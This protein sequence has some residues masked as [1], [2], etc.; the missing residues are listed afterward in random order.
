MNENQKPAKDVLRW[1]LSVIRLISGRNNPH[2][3]RL[4]WK[5]LASKTALETST[6]QA[7]L[8][9]SGMCAKH[10]HRTIKHKHRLCSEKKDS[11][12]WNMQNDLVSALV[13]GYPQPLPHQ[14]SSLNRSYAS[15]LFSLTSRTP[16]EILVQHILTPKRFIPSICSHS[17]VCTSEAPTHK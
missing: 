6:L 7:R 12:S 1:N 4:W 13:S 16:W 10:V 5:S 3:E 11:H 9:L 14:L 2:Q 15:C 8:N 17:I